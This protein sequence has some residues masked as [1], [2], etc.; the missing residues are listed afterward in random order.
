MAYI[1]VYNTSM[2]IFFTQ[3]S[4]FLAQVMNLD[5][6]MIAI[7]FVVS[8]IR[9]FSHHYYLEICKQLNSGLNKATVM[10]VAYRFINLFTNSTFCIGDREQ[11]VLRWSKTT[12]PTLVWCVIRT[13]SP[14]W[15]S[16]HSNDWQ[17][18]W[19]QILNLISKDQNN[20]LIS[21]YLTLPCC[22]LVWKW[23]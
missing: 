12:I 17:W 8:V 16:F 20:L 11:Q 14:F 23:Q 22:N 18:V 10:V 1:S 3:T 7:V 5:W 9:C 19:L 13:Y 6:K 2:S 4:V 15:I 21:P